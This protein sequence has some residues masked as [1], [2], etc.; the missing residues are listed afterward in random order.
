MA[1]CAQWQAWLDAALEARANLHTGGAVTSIA[2]SG[3]KR[4][5]YSKADPRS[6]EAWITRCQHEVDACANGGTRRRAFSLFPID[7]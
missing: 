1:T 5:E 6:L 3:G 7:R 2:T 4:I